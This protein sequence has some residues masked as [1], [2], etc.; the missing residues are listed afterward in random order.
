[1]SD[2]KRRTNNKTSPDS[3][4]HSPDAVNESVK[5]FVRDNEKPAD[6]FYRD[7]KGKATIGIG[8]MIPD[9]EAA[10]NL[11]LYVYEGRDRPIR[12]AKDEEKAEA[13]RRVMAAPIGQVYT[14]YDPLSGKGLSNLRLKTP[15]MEFLQE[16][17]LRE[18]VRYL[19]KTFPDLPTYPA[20]ARAA[21]QDM[22]YQI[23]PTK[24]KETTWEK[25]FPAVRDRDWQRAAKESRRNIH[26]GDVGANERN[27]RNIETRKLFEE[28]DRIERA[29]KKRKPNS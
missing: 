28:A 1:M 25:L 9:A 20:P 4:V 24:F 6:Y 26:N 21:L 14:E 22:E 18:G 15:D 29:R 2:T 7:T 16:Q 19:H 3:W 13:Y 10:K 5:K 27:R 17:R 11:P 12:P 23:G 8:L